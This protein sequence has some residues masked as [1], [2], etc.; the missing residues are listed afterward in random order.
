MTDDLRLWYTLD[1]I[2]AE[3]LHRV[4]A[5]SVLIALQARFRVLAEREGRRFPLAVYRAARRLALRRAPSAYV[6]GRRDVDRCRRV[7]LG[8]APGWAGRT[9]WDS[10][11]LCG[12]AA[13]NEVIA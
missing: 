10:L 9:G 2:P 13:V 3:R 11:T 6:E 5:K 4:I 12:I 1:V 7:L 8:G